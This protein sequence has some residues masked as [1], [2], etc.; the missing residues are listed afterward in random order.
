MHVELIL[1]HIFLADDIG[2]HLLLGLGDAQLREGSGAAGEVK[3]G[4]LRAQAAVRQ[5]LGGEVAWGG[6]RGQRS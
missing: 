5:V 6:C 3:L 1:L 4:D 2:R